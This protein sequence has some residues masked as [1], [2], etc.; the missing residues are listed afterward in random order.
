[1]KRM[2]GQP[3]IGRG[4][5][6]IVPPGSPKEKP[7]RHEPKAVEV[8]TDR[9]RSASALVTLRQRSCFVVD[10]RAAVKRILL[11]YDSRHQ[12]QPKNSSL[13][14]SSGGLRI[15]AFRVFSGEVDP[16]HR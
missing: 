8:F 15:T 5:H 11:S 9:G 7:P 13:E 6:A 10:Q 1:M 3:R 16:V 4:R 14:P 12:M 2:A